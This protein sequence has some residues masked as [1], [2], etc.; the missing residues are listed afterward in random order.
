MYNGLT[1][2]LLADTTLELTQIAKNN[3]TRVVSI[4][5][6]SQTF[7]AQT[8]P[9]CQHRFNKKKSFYLNHQE[10]HITYSG[11]TFPEYAR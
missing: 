4:S 7:L 8:M 2:D 3:M 6:I 11:H 9:I 5:L 10:I 1:L